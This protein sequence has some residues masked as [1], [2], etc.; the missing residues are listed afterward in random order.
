MWVL[1]Q[2]PDSLTEKALLKLS[3]GYCQFLV[4]VPDP[5]KEEERER[6]S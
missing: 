3:G 4:P 5:L 2:L 1:T 6:N